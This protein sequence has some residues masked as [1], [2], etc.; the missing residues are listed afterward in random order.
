MAA[1]CEERAPR[2]G[3]QRG[4]QRGAWRVS[5]WEM[6]KAQPSSSHAAP[7]AVLWRAPVAP[8][9]SA[10]A[11][12]DTRRLRTYSPEKSRSHDPQP[13]ARHDKGWALDDR[14]WKNEP[15]GNA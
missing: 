7:Q 3:R 6:Q 5:R 14:I 4:G 8:L 2:V 13:S 11:D 15:H 1:C 12:C 10:P 9:W